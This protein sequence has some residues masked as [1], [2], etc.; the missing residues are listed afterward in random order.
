[1]FNVPLLSILGVHEM[2]H[3]TAA[4]RHKVEVTPPFFLPAPSF[5]GTFGA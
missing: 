3:Y 1:M 4:R 2:G 5:I